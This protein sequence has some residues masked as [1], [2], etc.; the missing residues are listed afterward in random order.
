MGLFDKIKAP[1]VT[2]DDGK[3]KFPDGLWKKC[4]GCQEILFQT[5]IENNFNVCPKCQYHY[6]MPARDRIKMLVDEGSFVE[7]DSH[8]LPLDPL[9]F[10]DSKKYND[11]LKDSIKKVGENEAML[12]GEAKIK[13][14]PVALAVFI[15]EFMG[16]SMGAVV[17][18]KVARTFELALKTNIPAIV[19]SSSGGARMQEGIISLMQMAKTSVTLVKLKEKR[20]PFI[21]LCCDPTTGGVAAS[22]AMQGDIIIA[23]PNALIGFAGP[24]VIEQTIKEKLPQ[25]FQRAEF[26]LEHGMIDCIIHRAELR[27][28]LFKIL[29]ILYRRTNSQGL[30]KEVQL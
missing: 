22:F 12:Y 11:R 7:Y 16:G 25:G 1:K 13:N 6:K 10:R 4:V 18:E 23:E 9:Q 26:L 20:I 19:I 24:R 8:I 14:I 3:A 30:S 29:N 17:G 5:D 15:F 2:G 21:S 27:D 28:F